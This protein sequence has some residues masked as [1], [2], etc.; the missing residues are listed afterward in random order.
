MDQAKK[1]HPAF[2]LAVSLAIGAWSAGAS[3]GGFSIANQN[4]SGLGNAFAGQAAAAENASTIFFNPAG[5]TLLPGREVVGGVA[6]LRPNIKFNDAGSTTPTS[7]LPAPPGYARG[8]SGGDAGDWGFV[9]QGYLSWELRP[10]TLWAGVG[11]S[12]PFG[13]TT[14]WDSGWIGRFHAVKSELSA[15]NLNPSIAWKVNERFS[16]GGGINLQYVKAELTR[17]VPYGAVTLG[18]VLGGNPAACAGA[19]AGALGGCAAEGSS[20]VE[21]DDWSWGWNLGAMIVFSPDTRMGIAYRSSIKHKLEGDVSF[22]NVPNYAVLGAAGAPLG[23]AFS[24]G[25]VTA[26]L[27]VPATF[28]VG[29]SHQ[30]NRKLQLLAD[31]T[32]TGW[33]SVDNLVINRT[34][35][36]TLATER[37]RFSNGWRVGLG[38]NYQLNDRWK[39]RFGTA[40]DRSP[41]QDDFRTPRLPDDSRV[42]LAFGAQVALNRQLSID[43]GYA[44]E[45]IDDAPSRLPSAASA[46]DLPKG[47]LVG[48]YKSHVDLV[49]VQVR[50]R[51]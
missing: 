5:M 33:D 32:W 7:P 8:G 20:K 17:Q 1:T 21:G 42:W 50:Y 25:S 48:T 31:Y 45:F 34:N 10:G 2:P 12:A 19:V 47:A 30:L 46:S 11:L 9:P 14:E 29:F 51:F 26:E 39:L 41:V 6:A 23:A 27:E 16:V 36:S 49:G 18:R 3:A 38:A 40:Y 35:G 15:V 37:L 24:N 28:S 44:H 43:V 4:G 13:L 22:A